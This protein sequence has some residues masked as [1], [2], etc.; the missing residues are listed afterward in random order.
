MLR[1]IAR[2]LLLFIPTLFVILLISFLLS[3]NVPGDPVY[4]EMD[5]Q[6]QRGSALDASLLR[7]EYANVSHQLG[8]D[9]PEFYFSLT[10]YAYPDTLHRILDLSDRK[11]LANLV[12]QFG[13]WEMISAYY[14]SLQRAHR[15]I[16]PIMVPAEERGLKLEVQRTI[17]ELRFSPAPEDVNYRLS[18]LDSI[19][20]ISP[21]VRD[22]VGKE[23]AAVKAAYHSVVSAPS[24]WK[25]YVPVLHFH[26]FQNQFHTWVMKLL[27]GDLGRS[28]ID[29]RPVITKI[30]E[31]LPWTLFIG[32]LS[33]LIAYSMAIPLGVYGVRNRNLWQDNAVTVGL[34][35]MNAIPTFVS[36]MFLMTFFCNRDYLQLFPTSGVA[37]DGSERWPWH[38]RMIDHAYHLILPTL[39]ISYHSVA[40]VSRQLRSSMLETLNQDFIRTARAKG[41]AEKTVIWRHNLR[42]A[43]LPLVTHLGTLLPAMVGGAVITETIFSI[44]GMG[45]L[46]TTAVF[47]LDHPTII[48]VFTI[49]AIATLLGSLLS[50][51][52][53]AIV[54]PRISFTRK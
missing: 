12:D 1:Y 15:R 10:S 37:S 39:V 49:T 3:R 41:L 28:Y 11:C 2:R 53:L 14:Q 13:N 43:L 16:S 44:P 36:A 54:D 38:Y 22:S 8:Y 9:Q 34:F 42:N 5:R 30:N 52:L 20:G 31:A 35:L 18:F 26:G 6:F 33:Y 45:M 48:A 21:W 4:N 47:S 29:K 50:D 40:F 7:R 25:L 27:Q 24:T 51:V 17:E 46:S 19:V 23:L 32:L